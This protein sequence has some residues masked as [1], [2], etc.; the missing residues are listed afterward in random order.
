MDLAGW[1]GI[2][3]DS[4]LQATG[5]GTVLTRLLGGPSLKSNPS[6]HG[7]CWSCGP[8]GRASA[9]HKQEGEGEHIIN[10][11]NTPTDTKPYNWASAPICAALERGGH[12]EPGQTAG[13]PSIPKNV[14]VSQRVV[15]GVLYLAS[16]H[17]CG[18]EG[19]VLSCEVILSR[20]PRSHLFFATQ[21][22]RGLEWTS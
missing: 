2:Q 20:L 13:R 1:L 9:S 7:W 5:G 6:S 3:R 10:E 4:C 18:C 15:G 12:P 14:C 11:T 19:L 21:V 17:V 16:N 8:A 22:L